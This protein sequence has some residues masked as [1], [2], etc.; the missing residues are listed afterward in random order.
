MKSFLSSGK[1]R[2]HPAPRVFIAL[3]RV[4]ERHSVLG[5]EHVRY[6]HDDLV[7]S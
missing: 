6:T 3:N 4:L 1:R 7:S 5:L 2:T